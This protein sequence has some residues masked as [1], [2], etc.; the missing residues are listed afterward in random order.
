MLAFRITINAFR[1]C[2]NSLGICEA[3]NIFKYS[4]I[5]VLYGYFCGIFCQLP[6]F[7]ST[8]S[9][10]FFKEWNMVLL[11]T[12]IFK[13]GK[14]PSNTFF[15]NQNSICMRGLLAILLLFKS[16]CDYHTFSC[17]S[18]SKDLGNM[19]VYANRNTKLNMKGAE[20]WAS[21]FNKSILFWR[22]NE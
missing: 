1:V 17:D 12:I 2:I 9:T 5:F 14:K 4:N 11:L 8:E 7:K 20:F 6:A 3:W 21:W 18:H 10:G 16:Y 13:G 19:N 22:D 15:F